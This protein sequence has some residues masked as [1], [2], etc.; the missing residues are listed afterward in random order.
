MT[1]TQPEISYAVRLLSQFMHE[2]RE[3]LAYIKGTAGQGLIYKNN[4]NLD[5]EASS[6]YA[7]NRSDRK[8]TSGY[9]TYVGG[10]LVT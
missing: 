3:V 1:V 2:P 4:G 5:I 7:G 10:N 6:G 8:S 9:C